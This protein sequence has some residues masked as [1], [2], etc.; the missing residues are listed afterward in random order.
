MSTVGLA[1]VLLALAVACLLVLVRPVVIPQ[2]FGLVAPFGLFYLPGSVQL[3]TV[4]ALAV[5]SLALW[6]RLWIGQLPVPRSLQAWSAI[7]WTV[8][9][10]FSVVGS[11]DPGRA[12]TFG[13]W[14]IIAA[15]LA[16]S[17]AVT[18]GRPDRARAVL[19]AWLVGA[20]AVGASGLF[21]QD[22][23]LSE[24]YG[25]AV[26]T[27]RAVGVFTQPNEYGTYC[28]LVWLFCTGLAI[29]T[30]GW[31][32]YLALAAGVACLD[33][34]ITSFSRGAW[35]GAAFGL[36]VLAILA[37][38]ARRPQA[39]GL[40]AAGVAFG[41]VLIVMPFWELPGLLATRVIS[42]VN[43]EANPFDDR[44]ALMAEGLRQFGKASLVG[45]GPNMYSPV[46][47]NVGSL[48]RTIGGEHP[49]NFALA[50]AAEQG[51]IGLL[52]LVGFALA[53]CLAVINS[54]HLVR[55]ARSQSRR[56]GV[57]RALTVVP[58]GA[59]VALSAGA[60]LAGFVV[61]GLVDYPMRNALMRTTAWTMIG[62]T[63]AGYRLLTAATPQPQDVSVQVEV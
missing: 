7:V 3:I 29:L 48:A 56:P 44:P 55:R 14:Q 30:R 62:W 59:A 37:P 25:G 40:V 12:A 51:L 60:S 6:E 41:S 35:L 31:T 10:V 17:F 16:V 19:G 4:A 13:T 39:I 8:G 45:Q 61:E 1:V 36:V 57:S 33:G 58:L 18:V 22:G 43:P 63:L 47:A 52:A 23:G 53:A 32:R 42:I 28:M 49:H 50:V 26:V 2:A 27:G 11:K 20:L 46:S 34:L 54:R 38:Q 9:V 21:L 15:W 24:A 5:I